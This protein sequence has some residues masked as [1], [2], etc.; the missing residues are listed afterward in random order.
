MQQLAPPDDRAGPQWQS[1]RSGVVLSLPA[2][3][4]AAAMMVDCAI[5]ADG[6]RTEPC[7]LAEARRASKER[8]GFAWVDLREP[9]REEF[10]S[11]ARTF[12]L[13]GLA[14]EDAV[15]AHQR[16][17]V[18]HYGETLFV[19]LK[20]ARYVEETDKVEFGEIHAFVGEDF[21]VTV[22]HGRPSGLGDLRQHLEADPERLR[23]GPLAVLHAVMDLVV[24]GYAPVVDGLGNDV[25]A[26]ETEVFGGNANVSRRIYE[27]S[28]EVIEFHRA[29]QPLTGALQ[30]LVEGEEDLEVEARRYLRDVRDHML[31]VSEQ[32]EGF[33][34]LL[35]NILN[36]NLTLVSVQQN[37]QMQ[38]QNEQVQK[39]SAWAAILIVPTIITGIYGMNFDMMPELSWTF[40]YP[41]ALFL[42]VAISGGL[43]L[44]FKRSGW[45]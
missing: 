20:P 26:V 7:P 45:L 38:R 15:K 22:S 43:Y 13:H 10:G 2:Y 18:E 37:T 23:K 36:V 1:P 16:P 44:R 40:G 28:R 30:R 24:D 17:K 41:F 11:V 5:Y 39:I 4:D 3:Y 35:Q 42:M 25:D 19:V 34:E 14:V 31:R 27:L 33:R 29:T 6:R 21:I 9:T 8:G 12:D 32:V